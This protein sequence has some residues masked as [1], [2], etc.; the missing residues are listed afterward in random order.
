M[1]Y[2]Q[3]EHSSGLD[4]Q[5]AVSL[6][7]KY[8]SKF[9]TTTMQLGHQAAQCTVGTVNWRNMYGAEAF[10]LRPPLFWSQIQAIEKSKQ[11]NFDELENSARE[12][13]RTSTDS[14]GRNGH[15]GGAKPSVQGAPSAVGAQARDEDLPPGWAIARDAQ[16]KVY[17]WH[18]DTKAVQWQRP[19]APAPV[20]AGNDQ[21]QPAPMDD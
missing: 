21:P 18:R 4:T 7:S 13:A 16:G 14:S 6:Y 1:F 12:Y 9:V 3:Q 2:V 5:C 11:I 10:L 20:E 8:N 19:S 15:P 17:Y